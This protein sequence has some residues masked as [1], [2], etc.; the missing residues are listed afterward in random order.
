M[1][2]RPETLAD[3]LRRYKAAPDDALVPASSVVADL[4]RVEP[5]AAEPEPGSGQPV[6]VPETTWRQKL[7][8]APA[9]C[10]IGVEEL[11]EAL[12][13]SPSW[14]YART[15]ESA[16]PRLPHGKLSGSLVFRCGEVRAWLR[17]TEED[18]V[19]YRMEPAPG[20]LRVDRRA[21]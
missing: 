9:E 11:S 12:G 6:E 5:E 7:W 1:S 2:D 17:D 15:Q 3:V 21:S 4:E 19:G 8:T 20:E 16:D 18:V 10:R 13:R 14:I